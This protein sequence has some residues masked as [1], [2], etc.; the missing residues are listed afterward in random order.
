MK[1]SERFTNAYNRID[2]TLRSRLKSDQYTP[3]S[4]IVS[5]SAKSNA[6]IRRFLED[7]KKVR[8]LKKCDCS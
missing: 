6:V 1:N 4:T 8:E 7:L 2:E 5:E 3:F